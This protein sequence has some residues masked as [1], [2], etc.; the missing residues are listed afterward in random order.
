[1]TSPSPWPLG[2]LLVCAIAILLPRCGSSSSPT[3]ATPVATMPAPVTTVLFQGSHAG[4]DPQE[5][6]FL[7]VNAPTAG[8]LTANLGWTFPGDV[9]GAFW[10][11]GACSALP[12]APFLA[13][14]ANVDPLAPQTGATY[15]STIA[16]GG[17]YTLV[18]Q[19][20]AENHVEAVSL[21]VTLT[22]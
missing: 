10:A 1:M 14:S 7:A 2:R 8:T 18:F 12:C 16:Q 6:V 5:L 3:S 20:A 17:T 9:F 19:G 15:T 13:T 11:P 22:R 4:I 21:T